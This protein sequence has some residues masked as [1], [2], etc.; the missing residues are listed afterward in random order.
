[1]CDAE[2]V[3]KG[4]KLVNI[5]HSFITNLFLKLVP[6]LVRRKNAH[7]TETA[8]ARR[9]ATSRQVTSNDTNGSDI[10]AE[11]MTPQ[12]H[13]TNTEMVVASTEAIE[14]GRGG[15]PDHIG[16]N[17]HAKRRQSNEV[18]VPS[19][20]Q[21]RH[22]GYGYFD[23]DSAGIGADKGKAVVV[24]SDKGEDPGHLMGLIV[25]PAGSAGE[26]RR[27]GIFHVDGRFYEDEEA[28][29]CDIKSWLNTL[30]EVIT[31]I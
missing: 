27:V 16:S 15:E 4:W 28:P 24:S 20:E 2:Q 5:C 8:P 18:T 25:V 6:C 12:D 23:Y 30:T 29:Y 17:N 9:P 3:K 19:K 22:I 1:M 21:E 14:I 26:F 7:T 31:I 13:S 11:A 10:R